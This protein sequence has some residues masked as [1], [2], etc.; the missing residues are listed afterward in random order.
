MTSTSNTVRRLSL[1]RRILRACV[2]VMAGAWTATAALA[3]S[4]PAKPIT[5]VVGYSPG[6]GAD[7]VARL[8]GQKMSATLGQPVIV[9]NRPGSAG[10][11]AAAAVARSAPDGYTLLVDA[12]AFAINPSL[13]PKLSYKPSSFETV[14]VIATLPLL[15]V[16]H[17]SFPART[18]EELVAAA[19]ARPGSIFYAS[20]GSGSLMNLAAALFEAQAGVELTQVPYKGAG[21]ALNDVVGGQVPLYFGNAAATMPFVKG[22][23]LRPLAITAGARSAELPNV[24]TMQEVR[25]GG[26]ELYEWNAMLAP[27]GTPPATL[28]RLAAALKQALAAPDVVERLAGLG[29]RPFTGSRAEGARFVQTE[30]TRLGQV[31]HDRHITAE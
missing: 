6:G 12:S 14:R 18:I 17:P 11:I 21:A 22:G 29:A 16:V 19:K 27:A 3:Q 20:S 15:V 25:I 10:Q 5:L 26:M 30:I 24:P 2:G 7:I 28:D 13:Y 31:V 9:D 4:W 8:V 1:R 23:K